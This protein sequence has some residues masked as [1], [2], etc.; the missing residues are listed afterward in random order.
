M[1]KK[2]QENLKRHIIIVE[3]CC[4]PICNNVAKSSKYSMKGIINHAHKVIF[5]VV[6]YYYK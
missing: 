4:N 3:G 1:I 5:V 6:L 2:C